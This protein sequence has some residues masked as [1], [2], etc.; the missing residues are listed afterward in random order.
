MIK[1]RLFGSRLYTHGMR[2]AAG[3]AQCAISTPRSAKKHGH[4][5]PHPIP[6]RLFNRVTTF[7]FYVGE[8]DDEECRWTNKKVN[9]VLLIQCRYSGYIQV[10]PRNIEPM[11]GRAAAKWCAQTWMGDWDVPSE[12][13][14][15]SGKEYT[16]E[17]WRQLCTRIRIYHL[18]CK[19]H[20]H[21]TLPGEGAGRPHINMLRKEPASEK[22]FHWLQ[23][24]FALLRSYHNTPL[25]H[26]RS[27]NEIVLKGKRF[28]WNMPLNNPQPCKDVSLIMDE[29]QRAEKT[30]SKLVDKYQTDWLW[31][32]NKG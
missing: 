23:I 5:K 25:H 6:E 14:T 4:L 11:N 28:W 10:L 21:R 17:W 3:C 20:S 24:P 30:V 29:I 8:L 15:D 2:V 18:R 9:G 1:H 16:S 31:V 12:V 19:I 7:F 32:Q 13:I 27:P 26:G 22:D